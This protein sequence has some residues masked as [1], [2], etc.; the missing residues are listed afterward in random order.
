MRLDQALVTAGLAPSRA[1]AQALIAAGAV[2]VDGRVAGKSSM[3]VGAGAALEVD[4]TALPWVSRAALKLIAGL[5]TFG[6]DPSGAVA[7]DLGASTGGF[8]QVLLSRGAAEVWAV[9]VGHGQLAA[10]LADEPRLHLIEG[11]NVRELTVGHVPPPDFVVADLSFIPLAV[12]LPPALRLAQPGASLV[13]L[14]K[15]QFEVG[16][17]RVGKGGIVRDPAAWADAVSGAT[18][19][20]AAEGWTVLGEAPSPIEGGDGNREFLVAARK[21]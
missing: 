1:R 12:A 7:L 15:P 13:V 5:D 6:L 20:L 17:G 3:A 10:E 8:S 9:D 19:L 18:A 16:P 4:A 21:G 2:T 11:L 14:V